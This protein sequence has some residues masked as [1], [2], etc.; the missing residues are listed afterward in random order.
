[1]AKS[2]YLEEIRKEYP[3]IRPSREDDM[4]WFDQG[5]ELLQSDELD[6]AEQIFKKLSLSQPQHSDGFHG[7]ALVYAKRKDRERAL[8][9]R[10]E[11]LQRAETMVKDGSMD[12]EALEMIRTEVEEL[13]ER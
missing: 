9:F 11:A 10:R 5:Y 3:G 8:F 12:E 7:L 1:M 2:D 4:E 6:R 13:L